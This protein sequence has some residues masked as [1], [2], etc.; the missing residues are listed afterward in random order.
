[1]TLQLVRLRPDIAAFKRWG[2][3]HRLLGPQ[4]DDGYAWH[5]LLKAVLGDLAP[6]PFVVRFRNGSDAEFLAYTD[7]DIRQWQ[8]LGQDSDALR[9]LRLESLD[10]R[11][12]PTSFRAG[13]ALSFEVRVRPIVRTRSGRE[14]SHEL[15]AAV[16]ARQQDPEIDRQTAYLN[17]L[18]DELGR[19]DAAELVGTPRLVRFRRTRVMRKDR[20]GKR[21]RSQTV[22]GPDALFRGQLQVSNPEGFLA[23]VRRGLGRHRAFGF[24]CLLLAPP[25][26]LK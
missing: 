9:A 8:P 23:L 5:A 20:S 13:D 17:W 18:Q 4:I 19:Q 26:A 21:T 16:H 2:Y 7:S 15:D 11:P 12:L 25:G 22:E 6:R 3:Q 1:M 24:G 10:S 14:Q